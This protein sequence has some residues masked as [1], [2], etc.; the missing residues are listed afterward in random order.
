VQILG[1]PFFEY[2]GK[3]IAE[4]LSG[5]KVL[6]S[7]EEMMKSIEEFYDSREAAGI[8]KRHTHEI[9]DF[10][11]KFIWLVSAKACKC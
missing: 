6:P 4:L 9:G 5:K 3:W 11:V 1:L 10:E 8:H 2:Q 7:C